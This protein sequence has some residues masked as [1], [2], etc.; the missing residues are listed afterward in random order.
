MAALTAATRRGDAQQPTLRV[1]RSATMSKITFCPS[2]RVL[3]PSVEHVDMDQKICRAFSKEKPR[4]GR[5]KDSR[6]GLVTYRVVAAMGAMRLADARPSKAI[7]HPGRCFWRSVGIHLEFRRMVRGRDGRRRLS[8]LWPWRPAG[9]SR[10]SPRYNPSR[11]LTPRREAEGV[12]RCRIPGS[13][14]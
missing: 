4:G 11:S 13:W 7:S 5:G 14:T 10:R 12:I 8:G 1:R 3:M 6:V 9:L 2:L